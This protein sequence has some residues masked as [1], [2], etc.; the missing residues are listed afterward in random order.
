MKKRSLTAILMTAVLTIGMCMPVFAATDG[1]DSVAAT[2][3][4]TINYSV[5]VS[6]TINI[7]TTVTLSSENKAMTVS[8][9][10]A[11]FEPK[12]N[13]SVAISGDTLTGSTLKLANSKDSTKTIDMT[14]GSPAKAELGNTTDS[15]S[16][17]FT[18]PDNATVAGTYSAT[19]IFTVSYQTGA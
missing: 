18:L 12:G 10:K 6:Y 11:V 7:P 15:L 1:T 9:T 16:Y 5:P 19:V 14:I 3:D 4:T 13:V 2:Q 8:L 17:S